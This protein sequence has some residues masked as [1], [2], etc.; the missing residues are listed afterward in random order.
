MPDTPKDQN[1]LS[2]EEAAKRRDEV[3]KKMLNTPPKPHKPKNE[4]QE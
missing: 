2:E 1:E 4:K 3:L